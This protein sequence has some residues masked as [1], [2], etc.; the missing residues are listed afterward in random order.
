MFK[1][2]KN[3]T[4]T[5]TETVEETEEKNEGRGY[6]YANACDLITNVLNES[7]NE[8]DKILISCGVPL[9]KAV[10]IQNLLRLAEVRLRNRI[11]YTNSRST[12]IEKNTETE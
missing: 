5:V 10:E 9:E 7:R 8:I 12:S 11:M 6:M 3:P 4:N 2:K 1:K